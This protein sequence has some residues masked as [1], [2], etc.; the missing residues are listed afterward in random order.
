MK[1]EL[2]EHILVTQLFVDLNDDYVCKQFKLSTLL[3]ESKMVLFAPDYLLQVQSQQHLINLVDFSVYVRNVSLLILVLIYLRRAS[4]SLEFVEKE[5]RVT[6][7]SGPWKAAILYVLN[8]AANKHYD[9]IFRHQFFDLNQHEELPLV[10]F[11]DILC[12]NFTR[13]QRYAE[14]QYQIVPTK[15]QKRFLQH[16]ICA[17]ECFHFSEVTKLYANHYLYSHTLNRP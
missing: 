4:I 14:G 6:K 16:I 12:A 10:D 5:E 3:T 1:H 7:I 15:K 17:K 2:V 11:I 13:Y 8:R 9:R